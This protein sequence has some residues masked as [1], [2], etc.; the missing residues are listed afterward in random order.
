MEHGSNESR[1]LLPTASFFMAKRQ[2][3]NVL[4]IPQASEN[5]SVLMPKVAAHVRLCATLQ[6][7][8]TSEIPF[9]C[10]SVHNTIHVRHSFN[11]LKVSF[12]VG[13]SVSIYP[14]IPRTGTSARPRFQLVPRTG[15]QERTDAQ[16]VDRPMS[17]RWSFRLSTCRDLL[18][19]RHCHDSVAS[20]GWYMIGALHCS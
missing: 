10:P 8:R 17:F 2:V 7:S 3:T 6:Y 19:E 14:S 12:A 11:A 15:Q 20:D 13:F 4:G 5:Q 1:H 9:C 18:G 16:S